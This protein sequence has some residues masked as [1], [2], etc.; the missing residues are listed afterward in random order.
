MSEGLTA[1]KAKLESDEYN[2]ITGARRA[3]GKIKGLLP[4]EAEKAHRM[5]NKYFDA[6]PAASAK[7]P[8]AKKPA[9]KAAPAKGR[10]KKAAP[11]KKPAKPAAKKPVAA[12]DVKTVSR[13]NEVKGKVEVTTQIVDNLKT[14]HDMGVDVSEPLE[15]ARDCFK[16]ALKEIGGVTASFKPKKEESSVTKGDNA[17]PTPVGL[18]GAAGL[19]QR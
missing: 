18:P 15:M 4:G 19:A 10:K 14:I 8:A 9:K 17:A 13:T 5:A 7:K 12:K 2:G 1:F 6:A 16:N 11:A 3:I